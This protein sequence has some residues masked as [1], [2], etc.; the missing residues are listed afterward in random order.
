[1]RSFVVFVGATLLVVVLGLVLAPFMTTPRP[2]RVKAE[3]DAGVVERS[4]PREHRSILDLAPAD[5]AAH[6]PRTATSAPAVRTQ[7]PAGVPSTDNPALEGLELTEA[8]SATLEA[9]HVPKGRTGL[10]VKSIH[11]ASSAAVANLHVGDVITRAQRDEVK[12]VESLRRAV[13]DREQTTI[14]FFREGHPF[15]V[16]LAKPFVPRDR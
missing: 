1:M 5:P 14:E 4:P 15:Y 7:P 10:V 13:G 16:V 3:T 2:R 8:D 9:M 12:D 11:P 6:R